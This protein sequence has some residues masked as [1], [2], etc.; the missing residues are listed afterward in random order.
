MGDPY[1]ELR[2]LFWEI[3]CDHSNRLSRI[4]FEVLMDKLDINFSKRKWKQI[5]REIDR[6]YDDE[7]T[8]EEFFFFLFPNH[9]V[10][11]AMEKKRMK[12]IRH[13]VAIKYRLATEVR[14]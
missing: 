11:K 7:V 10:S 1:T 9:D 8:F 4:E 14:K 5:Y 6:N 13:R 12:I 3:D 2:K